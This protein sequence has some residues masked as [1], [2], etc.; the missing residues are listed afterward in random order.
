MQGNTE[1]ILSRRNVI[2][3]PIS[4]W[5]KQKHKIW[6]QL[7]SDISVHELPDYRLPPTIGEYSANMYGTKIL[8]YYLLG[9]AD[10]ISPRIAN[11][12]HPLALI[13]LQT[14]YKYIINYYFCM[15]AYKMAAFS[16]M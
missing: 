16:H 7:L 2:C 4:D 13:F 11:E 6:Y 9:Y 1:G 5:I 8:G 3:P 15:F 10:C 12:V 14:R